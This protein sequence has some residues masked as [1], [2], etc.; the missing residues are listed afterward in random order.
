M[1]ADGSPRRR[2]SSGGRDGLQRLGDRISFTGCLY[3]NHSRSNAEYFTQ[4]FD[5]AVE[6]VVGRAQVDEQDLIFGVVDDRG[7][8]GSKLGQLARVELAEEYGE[9]GV[10][11][12][13][14]EVVEDFAAA[15][16]VGDVVADDVMAAGGVVPVQLAQSTFFEPGPRLC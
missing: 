14:F 10:V 9:L 4:A 8:I 15:F 3:H 13:T 6:W 2:S 16:V 11:A 12:A 5:A 1:A 7:Q